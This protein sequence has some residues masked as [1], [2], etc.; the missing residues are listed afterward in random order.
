MEQNERS[1]AVDWA[2][3]RVS[4]WKPAV[5]EH[6]LAQG[7]VE[8]KEWEEGE[9]EEPT[10]GPGPAPGAPVGTSP[11]AWSLGREFPPSLLLCFSPNSASSILS[12]RPNT[13]ESSLTL[14]FLSYSTLNWRMRLALL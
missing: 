5:M 12:V 13:W 6:P 11:R 3:R 2:A 9:R 7:S 8:M 14:F 1:V 4:R 10:M